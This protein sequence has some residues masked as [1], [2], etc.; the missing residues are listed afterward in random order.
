MHFEATS[1]TPEV[2]FNENR[3]EIKG[4]CYP[5][6]ISIFSEPIIEAL[7]ETIQKNDSITVEIAMRYFNSSSA[8]FFFDFFNI[9]HISRIFVNLRKTTMKI[10]SVLIGL[11]VQLF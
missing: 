4:E 2:T 9:R 7:H 11:F 1:R 5:E 6:D 8:K 3:I 10:N